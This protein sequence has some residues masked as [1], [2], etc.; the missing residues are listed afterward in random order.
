MDLITQ[1]PK[2]QGHDAILTIVDQGCSRAAIFLPCQM[3]ITGE[4]VAQL[5]AEN[6]Y[7]WFGL[8]TKVISDQDPHFT[9]HFARA[10]CTKLQI[11]QNMSTAFH[12]QTDGLSE[13]KNQWVEQY[14]RLVT[15]TQQDDWKRWLPLATLVYN[16][17]YNGTIKMAPN[18]ALLGYLPTLNPEAP[19]N[20]M[21]ERIEDQMALAHEYQSKARQPSM[22]KPTSQ[23]TNL[24]STT[25][26]G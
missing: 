13:R 22:Q 2:S 19:T 26:C 10:L 14:L 6:V 5:Y 9:S 1:L 25:V 21:N 15:S 16:N 20:M 11:K 23:K 7:Q 8:P 4:E 3:T 18:Q 17:Q 24:K 12:P